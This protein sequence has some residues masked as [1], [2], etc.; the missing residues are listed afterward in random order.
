MHGFIHSFIH[1]FI[2]SLACPTAVSYRVLDT[3]RHGGY[4]LCPRRVNEL[5]DLPCVREATQ[6]GRVCLGKKT[7]RSSHVCRM[8][9]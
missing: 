9:E 2:C 7:N 4:D 8:N 5:N 3:D 6:E 1:P